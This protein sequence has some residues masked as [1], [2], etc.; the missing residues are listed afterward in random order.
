[1]H[2][3]RGAAAVPPHDETSPVGPQSGAVRRPP[4]ARTP[5]GGAG[6]VRRPAAPARG[7]TTAA[8]SGGAQPPGGRPPGGGGRP[9]GGGNRSGGGRGPGGGKAPLPG[10]QRRR[11]RLKIALGV[12]GGLFLLL[13]V[14][15]GVVYATTEVP[16]P[17]SVQNAQT[18]VVYYADGTTEM[19]RM[20]SENRTNVTLDEVSAGAREAVLSAENRSFYTDPGVSFTG[21]LRAAWNDVTGSSTQGGSTITQQY[22]KNAFLNSDQTFSRKFKELFLAVKLGQNYSK[23]QILTNYLNTIYF[24]RGAYGIEAAA[25]TYFGVHAA[26][27]TPQQGAVLAVMVRN[28]SF[29]DPA[30][31]PQEAQARWGA[32]LDGMV[33]QGWMTAADRQSSTYPQVLPKADSSGLG[34][35]QG[36]EGLVVQQAMDELESKGYTEDQIRSGGLR[37]TT[38]VTKAAEDAAINAVATV[39]K[40]QHTNLDL[41]PANWGVLRQSLVAVD[42]KTGAVVAYYGGPKAYGPNAI[43]Y[44]QA[45]RQPGSSMKPYTLAT[46]LQ[47]GVSADALRLGPNSMKFPDGQTISNAGSEAC[48]ACSLKTAIT[49]SLNTVFYGEALDVGPTNVRQ[50]ALAATGM[51]DVWPTGSGSALTGKKTLTDPSTNGTTA[52][53]IGIGQYEMQPIDQAVGYATFASGG[54]YRAPYFVAKVTDG[55]GK[56]LLTNTGSAGKQV[57]P[58]DV[59]HDVGYALNGV[60]AWSHDALAG[61]RQSAAKTGTQNLAGS[62]I[63]NTDSW[64]V[65]YTPSLSAAVWMGSD[66]HDAIRTAA[67]RPIYG[68]GLPGQIW[69][70]FMD[71]ALR[72]TP[73]EKLPTTP[74]ITG[75]TMSDSPYAAAPKV[76]TTPRDDTA[77]PTSSAAPTSAPKRSSTPT[78]TAAPT[79]SDTPKTTSPSRSSAS[80]TTSGNGNGNGDDN[81][82][83]GGAP[84]PGDGGD[85]GDSGGLAVGNGRSGGGTG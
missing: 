3:E 2:D 82:D 52:A 35:P 72:G 29:Y 36:P 75:D 14:F 54:I 80:R 83:Q 48:S 56:V 55:A 81:G 18:T 25:N 66:G 1:M 37:I 8:R 74:A 69:K 57:L 42:P 31:H 39:M 70:S 9:P 58:G 28:P 73:M 23:D 59:A 53:A 64:M 79:E 19:A 65:G 43:D 41:D 77:A 24:G 50:T 71:A 51:P 34:M 76:D 10:K 30:A 78:P 7:R 46:G 20:G 13:C 22:V 32:V 40:G 61:G 45:H 6:A 62:K 60:A 67:G 17:A 11:R 12:V 44:A 63:D 68:A 4:S 33:K 15:I 16:D 47:R 38:T 21:I 49:E 26:Q 5:A 27:L 84:L 85:S